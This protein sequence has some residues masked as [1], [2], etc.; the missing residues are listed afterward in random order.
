M[1][2]EVQ[3][4]LTLQVHRYALVQ[5]CLAFLLRTNN[6]HI[7]N[8]PDVAGAGLQTPSSLNKPLTDPFPPNLQ[9]IITTK[10]LE[11]ES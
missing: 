8:R 6:I 10:P 3:S 4:F 9:N 11:L 7:F 5:F 2:V 1:L